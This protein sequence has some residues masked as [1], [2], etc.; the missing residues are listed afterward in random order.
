MSKSRALWLV[1]TTDGAWNG[2]VTQVEVRNTVITH[3]AEGTFIVA[4][5]DRAGR[6]Q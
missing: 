5:A 4:I 2:L 6:S 1:E 3:S